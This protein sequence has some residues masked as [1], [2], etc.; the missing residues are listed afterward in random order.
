MSENNHGLQRGIGLIQATATNMSQ[1]MG[2]GPF[3]TIPVILSAMGGPQAIFGWI[4]GAILAM[5]DGLVW[6]EL[7]SAMPG[8]G[9][10]YV[11]LREAFQYRTGKLIPFLFIWSTLIA[12]PLIMST[13]AIGLA[14][15]LSYFF[16]HMTGLDT[17]LVAVF[18]TII[19]VGL[20][21]RPIHSVA[22][23]TTVLWA[24]VIL[25]VVMVLTAAA[26]H[27]NPH[28]A[29]SFPHDA[30]APSKFL[31][32]LGSGML[33]S[34][35]DYMGYYTTSY[36]GDEVKNPGKT[37]PRS[38]LLSILLVAIIDLSMNI[39]IIGTV[40]WRVAMKSQDI[41]TQFM[42]IVWGRPGAI[43]ITLLIMWTAFASVY[44]G[45]LGASRIPYNAAMDG[46]FFKAFAKLHH[47]LKFPYISL[48][49]MGVIMAICCF[50]NLTQIINALMAM[51]IVVQFMG[52][53]VALTVLRKRQP[54]LRRPFRQWLYPIPSILAFI[55]WAYVFYSSGWPAIRLAIIWTGIGAIVFLVWAWR[56][57]EWPF[58][59]KL[60]HEV[61]LSQQNNSSLTQ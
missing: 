48:L 18:I 3:I 22:K 54:N 40:P 55:G 12:T 10:T 24:G 59:E 46:L 5:L 27:F 6:S 44:T 61:Y 15:Y 14:D 23:L 1:M 41:A 36:L 16:P 4:L 50:F 45:L 56:R 33:I 9:G 21:W 7:G 25:T 17:K 52:Q 51:T 30:F 8:E 32:G 43:I 39:G 20:L 38:I 49:V 19:T 31:L 53:I 11:Y 26:T 42:Q 60:I 2:A 28:V 13:G 35:Y 29:F 57:K 47:R 58:G 34:I 37:I